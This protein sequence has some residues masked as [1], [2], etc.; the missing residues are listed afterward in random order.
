M[1]RRRVL[2]TAVIAIVLFLGAAAYLATSGST[3]EPKRPTAGAEPVVAPGDLPAVPGGPAP[4]GEATTPAAGPGRERPSHVV[5]RAHASA[6]AHASAPAATV[7]GPEI[8][9]ALSIRR[10]AGDTVVVP[11]PLTD[12]SDADGGTDATEP[13]PSGPRASDPALGRP[14]IELPPGVAPRPR[15]PSGIPLP[16]PPLPKPPLVAPKPIIPPIP[17]PVPPVPQI[18]LPVPKPCLPWT[19]C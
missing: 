4:A 5:D 16:R 1:Q 17:L 7:P 13:R 15:I 6:H 2:I 11:P 12:G 8:G 19:G 18:K 3:N 10:R 14:R 9:D